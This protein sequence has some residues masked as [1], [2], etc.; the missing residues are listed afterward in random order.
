MCWNAETLLCQQRSVESRLWSSKWSC[1]VVRAGP[2]RRQSA[3]ELLPSSCCAGEPPGSP[4][5][6][7]E[8]KPVNLKG[9]QPWVLVRRV[10]AEAEGP[11][12]WS[13]GISSWFTGKVPDAGQD[14]GQKKRATENK[15]AGWHHQ[16]TRHEVEQTSGNGEGQGGLVCWSPWSC[17]YNRAKEQ[18]QFLEIKLFQGE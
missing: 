17:R 7:K 8:F 12:Y 2:Q 10:D 3:K 18:Q 15:M 1:T 9:D 13:C 6:S 4:L 16:C 5:D 11:L 14:W